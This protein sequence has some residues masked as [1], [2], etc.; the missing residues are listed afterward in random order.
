MALP[1]QL[2]TM[3]ANQSLPH[4]VLLEGGTQ[5]FRREIALELAQALLCE[6]QPQDPNQASLFGEPEPTQKPCNTCNHCHKALQNIHPDLFL[7][8]GGA[9]AR[10]FHIDA[11]RTIRQQAIVLPNEA[12][13]KVFVLHNAH[14]MTTEAQNALLKLLEEPPDYVCLILTAPARKLLLQTVISRVATVSL[15]AA[16]EEALD[17]EREA[18]LQQ[19][20]AAI[21]QAM[22][23]SGR[24]YAMLE[25]TAPLEGDRDLLRELLPCLRRALYA[26]LI[27]DITLAPRALQWID[28]LRRLEDALGRNANLNLLITRLAGLGL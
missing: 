28:D 10:S 26:R 8:E 24:P 7:A 4:A 5:A 14:T 25:A 27:E 16:A 21:T 17:P 1:T 3:L 22:L 23:Q 9:G 12:E 18:L 19:H 20:T 2:T 11:I 6:S 13:H 15:G